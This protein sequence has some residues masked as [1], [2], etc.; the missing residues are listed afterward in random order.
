M[1]P[2][3][4]RS[5]RRAFSLVELALAMGVAS[6]CLVAVMGLLPAGL[7]AVRM[8]REEAGASASLE[9]IS[10][11][12]RTSTIDRD[13]NIEASGVLSDLTWNSST[14]RTFMLKDFSVDGTRTE[15]NEEIRLVARVKIPPGGN[16]SA[17]HAQVSVAWPPSAQWN[18]T[19]G[20]WENSQ[21]ALSAWVVFRPRQ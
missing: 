21:G 13:G 12:L 1:K 10:H 20:K 4:S 15:N 11:S 2:F 7:D 9:R 14:G 8:S 18:E 6:F 16:T 3:S 5:L 19:T 17:S